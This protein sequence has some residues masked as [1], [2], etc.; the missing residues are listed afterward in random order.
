MSL[1]IHHLKLSRL[2][3]MCLLYLEDDV[4]VV[5]NV[6]VVSVVS[7]VLVVSVV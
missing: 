6:S 1:N 5:S 2:R 7:N 4:S 3:T